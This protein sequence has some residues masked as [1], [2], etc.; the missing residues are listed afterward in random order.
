MSNNP[1]LSCLVAL[2]MSDLIQVNFESARPAEVRM[3]DTTKSMQIG[4]HHGGE[5]DE[6]KWRLEIALSALQL[7]PRLVQASS[8]P[9]SQYG[10]ARGYT[11][12]R[13]IEDH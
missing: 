12:R 7:N 6:L 11:V 10:T 13:N 5:K 3:V 8:L 9:L 1:Q 4:E 2:Y